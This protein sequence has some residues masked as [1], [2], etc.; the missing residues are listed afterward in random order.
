LYSIF[1]T[2]ILWKEGAVMLKEEYEGVSLEDIKLYAEDQF[3]GDID[4]E[5]RVVY[6]KEK[7][8]KVKGVEIVNPWLDETG[9][10]DLDDD[11]AVATYGKRAIE[12]FCERVA[13]RLK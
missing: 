13:Y 9:M 8:S 2:I 11:E 3:Y 6:L 1:A 4:P 10:Y 5:Q 12:D 7:F